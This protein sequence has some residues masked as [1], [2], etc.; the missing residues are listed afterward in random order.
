MTSHITCPV[1]GTSNWADT[2]WRTD[3]C[4]FYCENKEINEML[5]SWSK[6]NFCRN[7][8]TFDGC[9]NEVDCEMYDCF[10]PDQNRI[11]QRAKDENI[12]VSDVIALIKLGNK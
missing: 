1:C 7:Y 4:H 9:E 12:S 8:D 6:C 2:K 11:I 10:R 3:T 5:N